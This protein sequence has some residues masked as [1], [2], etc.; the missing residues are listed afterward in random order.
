M[1]A[2]PPPTCRV[3]GLALAWAALVVPSIAPSILAQVPRAAA[4]QPQHLSGRVYDASTG[5]AVQ[6]ARVRVLGPATVALTD[7]DGRYQLDVP[8][9]ARVV[10]LEVTRIGYAPRT[11]RVITGGAVPQQDV[12]LTPLASRLAAVRV[13]ADRRGSAAARLATR[14]TGS[15]VTDGA[16]RE[17]IAAAPNVT[18][19]QAVERVSGVAVRDDRYAV[20]RGLGERYTPVTLNGARLPSASREGKDVSLDLVPA[21]FLDGVTVTK[22]YAADQP[23]DVVGGR[24][25]LETRAPPA[26]RLVQ[27]SARAGANDRTTGHRVVSAPDA[28]GE[29]LTRSSAARRLPAPVAAG[30]DL[31]SLSPAQVRTLAQAFRPVWT[32][33]DERVRP[34]VN[35]VGLIGG[36]LAARMAPEPGGEPAVSYLLGG[37]Y[38]TDVAARLGET[39]ALAR[40]SEGAVLP[41]NRFVGASST[42]FAQVA[43]LASLRANVGA[44]TRVDWRSVA[45]RATENGAHADT[46]LRQVEGDSTPARRTSLLFTERSVW[47]HQLGLA[48]ALGPRT[49]VEVA[50]GVSGT[51]ERQPDG[52]DFLQVRLESPGGWGPLQWRGVGNDGAKR[53]FGRVSERGQRYGLT[54][55]RTGG[56]G[57][58]TTWRLSGGMAYQATRRSVDYRTY[59]LFGVRFTDAQARQSPEVIFGDLLRRDTSFVV[60]VHTY[61][62]TATYDARESVGAAHAALEVPLARGLTVAAGARAERWG[63]RFDQRLLYAS[64]A[65]TPPR[66]QID[67]APALSVTLARLGHVARASLSQTLARPAYRELSI[68]GFCDP[69]DELCDVGNPRLRRARAT[70]ADLRWERYGAAGSAVSAGAFAKRIHDPIEHVETSD[71][72]TRTFV[73]ARAAVLWGAEVDARR[74]VALPGRGRDALTLFGN[75]TLAWS[76]LTPGVD[77]LSIETG[78]RRPITGATPV[79]ANVGLTYRRAGSGR[80]ADG[81]LLTLVY[82]ATGR[83]LVTVGHAPV[84][85]SYAAADQ[86][87]D[88]VAEWGLGRRLRARIEGRNLTASRYRLM[89]GPVER[90]AY[91]TGRWMRVGLT[92]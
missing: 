47:S 1:L 15:T 61:R 55:R 16:A 64:D 69:V 72:Q 32:P 35:L 34:S 25:S 70:N 78:R 53:T 48:Q 71:P 79:A 65:Q 22:S 62:T 68:T 46:G 91:D 77:S 86:R 92:W 54:I 33:V 11:L 49:T 57:D 7:E 2:T 42:E 37:S 63:L 4:N 84:P 59:Q 31:V 81:P 28:G 38:R 83:T 20:V 10:S 17:E 18:A 74:A 66:H 24:V 82:R 43:G 12:A 58:S 75:A 67:V 21:D 73:N 44:R 19:A 85:D 5:G 80:A 56:R 36:P 60:G 14:S 90:L 30:G 26:T 13:A 45:T 76:R 23:A 40:V 9:D 51:A 8:A 39:R 50:G 88:A 87:V 41:R 6:G 29:L 27:W 3:L 52:A 89:A